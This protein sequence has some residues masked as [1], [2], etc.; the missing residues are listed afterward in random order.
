[1]IF[2]FF[3]YISMK[4][5]YT[6]FNIFN[7]SLLLEKRIGQI[8]S[9]IEV[10]FN[11]EVIKTSHSDFRETRTDI[12]PKTEFDSKY[13]EKLISHGELVEFVNY[14]KAEIAEHIATGEIEDKVEFVIK[15][16]S[17][18]LAC[19]IIPDQQSMVHWKLILK[20]AWRE[21]PSHRF[22]VAKGQLVIIKP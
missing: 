1:M 14:F 3:I 4:N 19:P 17:R 18:Q 13:I 2:H 20:T 10:I 16:D 12:K 5:L 22:R 9:K 21:S 8:L 11:L 7:E 15:S 6:T